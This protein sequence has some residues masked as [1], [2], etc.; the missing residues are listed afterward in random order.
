M[1]S[2]RKTQ[3]IAVEQ[4]MSLAKDHMRQP[5]ID[6]YLNSDT[7]VV[8][9]EYSNFFTAVAGETARLNPSSVA[10]VGRDLWRMSKNEA[11]LFGEALSQS[12]SRCIYSGSR[13]TT[14]AKLSPEVLRVYRASVA[15]S[16]DAKVELPVDKKA[17]K[18][19]SNAGCMLEASS[20]PKPPAKA[21]TLK[22]CLSSPSQIAK[23]YAGGGSLQ[24]VKWIPDSK[25]QVP[26]CSCLVA[27]V[28]IMCA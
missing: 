12:F 17:K 20:P 4:L 28:R 27:H 7:D 3:T 21:L 22:K 5:N 1:P 2:K 9:K 23:L 10:A 14:G 6:I 11:K 18:A 15:N 19:T 26:T 25:E 24:M 13:C 16:P 8:V